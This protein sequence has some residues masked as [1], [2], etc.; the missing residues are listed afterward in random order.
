MTIFDVALEYIKIGF[1]VI[2]CGKD[3]KPLINWL[4]Y[5]KKKPERE[6]IQEWWSKKPQANIG[7]ITGK[8]SGLCVVDIDTEEGFKTISEY[9]PLDIDTPTARSPKGGMHYYFEWPGEGLRNNC[10]VITGCDLRA[11]GGYVVAPPSTNEAGKSYEWIKDIRTYPLA[12]LPRSYIEKVKS[13]DK[14]Q[15]QREQETSFLLFQEGRRD[16]DLFHA[17]HCLAK[18]GMKKGAIE[19]VLT[20]L[21]QGCNPPFRQK[22]AEA[23][24]KSALERTDRKE[25]DLLKE[26]YQW[27]LLQDGY[28]NVTDCYNELHLVTKEQKTALRVNLHRLCKKNVIEKYGGKSGVYRKVEKD[29]EEMAWLDAPTDEFLLKFP[30]RVEDYTR[31]Y[32]KNVILLS[33]AVNAG[34]TSFALEFARLNRKLFGTRIR[35]V[36]SEMGPT[37]LK[38]RL[39]L[40]PQEQHFDLNIW[41]DIEFVERSENYPDL[42]TGEQRIFILDYLELYDDIYRMAGIINDIFRRLEKGMALVIIQKD[43]KKEHGWGGQ[44]TKHKARLAMDLERGKLILRKVKSFKGEHSPDGMCREFKLAQGWKF[45]PQGGWHISGQEGTKKDRDFLPED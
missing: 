37:E 29:F 4:Q 20:L 8:I 2:P 7:I 43:P 44:A 28:I 3:K 23:K 16:E 13:A 24:V 26:I 33:G 12:E 36:S 38:N 25:R 6:E 1:S 30:L 21:A 32:P 39:L 18:G 41:K 10:R 11:E 27:I 9:F 35:Y 17:A 34:K 31:V 45:I 19:Q 40:Y 15:F 22:E 5:Q 14:L 42:I